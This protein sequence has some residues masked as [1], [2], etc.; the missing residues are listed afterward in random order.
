MALITVN[1]D[2]EDLNNWVEIALYIAA[3]PAVLSGKKWGF[4]FTIFVLVYTLST[5]VGI[6]IYYQVWLNAIRVVVNLPIVIYLFRVL[7]AGKTK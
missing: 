3:I 6:L 1:G 2:F 7:I 5:S 4:A